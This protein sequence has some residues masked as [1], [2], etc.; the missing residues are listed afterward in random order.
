MLSHPIL[1]VYFFTASLHVPLK[2]T[3]LE[4]PVTV[5]GKTYVE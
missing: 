3:S 2:K 5:E 4:L 1:A